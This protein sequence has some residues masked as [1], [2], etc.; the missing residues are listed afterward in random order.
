MDKNVLA[1]GAGTESLSLTDKHFL[2]LHR[3]SGRALLALVCGLL[4][5]AVAPVVPMMRVVYAWDVFAL[6]L[7]SEAWWLIAR[8]TPGQTRARAGAEDP[9]GLLVMA[10]AVLSSAFSL[11]AALLLVSGPGIDRAPVLVAVLSAWLL[12]HTAFA[13]RYAHL[14][15]RD[16]T[17]DGGEGVGGMSFPGDAPPC[18]FDFAYFSFTVG[19]CF[20]VSDIAITSSAIRR[21]TLLH[22]VLSYIYSTVVL[23]LVLNLTFAHLG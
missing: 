15:Y 9:G 12:T 6:V 19:M 14:Y 2:H 11:F 20:Q 23:A 1:V 17:S 3:A 5:G 4:A 18:D 16:C 8:S 22:A 7:T 13:L 21:T 10:F